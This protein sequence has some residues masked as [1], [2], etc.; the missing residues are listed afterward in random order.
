VSF[1]PDGGRLLTAHDDGI[2]RLWDMAT[3]DLLSQLA[4]MTEH[5]SCL[6]VSPDERLVAA[7]SVDGSV[8]LVDAETGHLRQGLTVGPDR[9]LDVGFTPGGEGLMAVNMIGNLRVWRLPD[10]T[11]SED[12]Q[13]GDPPDPASWHWAAPIALLSSAAL[14]PSGE[15]VA[16]GW[17]DGRV[18]LWRVAGA[19]PR[20]EGQGQEIDIDALAFSADETI[21]V[22]G[23]NGGERRVWQVA[24]GTMSPALAVEGFLTSVTG[25][26]AAPADGLVAFTSLLGVDLWSTPDLAMVR[27]LAAEDSPGRAAAAF[28]PD[29][30]LLAAGG[31]H[32]AL[33]LWNVEDGSLL[34]VLSGHSDRIVAASFSSG[35]RYLATGSSDGTVRFWGVPAGP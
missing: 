7:G 4:G 31:L 1:A 22:S 2:V 35:G 27:Q 15:L 16:F 14:S 12:L 17:T 9:V 11:V 6:A 20:W 28:S 3:G 5:V 32:G 19:R 21:L 18:V 34:H 23:S 8:W 26:A 10:L 24:D 33:E 13:F 25:A 30:Q 29:G